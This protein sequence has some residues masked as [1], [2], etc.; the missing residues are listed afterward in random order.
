M[1]GP[2][3]AVDFTLATLDGDSLTLASMRGQVV[4]VNFWATWCVPC[5]EE[6]PD[7]N[8][9]AADLGPKGLRI[10]GVSLDLGGADVVRTFLQEHPMHYPV[11]M[12]DA[13]LPDR[14]GALLVMPTTLVV[15]RE[16]K[17][18]RRLPGRLQTAELRPL[19]EGLL[20]G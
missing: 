13:G 11:V 8:R 5:R 20:A 16:G 14:I 19:L 18:V 4:L 3:E 17:L 15:N 12:G 2:G 7:L 1:A 10:V 6:I 9:L